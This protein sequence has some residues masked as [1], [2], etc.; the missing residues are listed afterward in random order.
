MKN[1]IRL[2]TILLCGFQLTIL[3]GGKSKEE[4]TPLVPLPSMPDYT[5]SS[6]WG[7]ALGI[8]VEYEGA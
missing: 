8:G 7:L 6:G 3:A 2:L 5:R 1:R 4:P